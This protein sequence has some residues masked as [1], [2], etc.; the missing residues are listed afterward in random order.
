M[1]EFIELEELNKWSNHRLNL[2][3]KGINKDYRYLYG[4]FGENDYS[5]YRDWDDFQEFKKCKKN[6]QDILTLR[7]SVEVE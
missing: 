7:E 4:M 2:Y 6:I 5:G 3:L 1:S